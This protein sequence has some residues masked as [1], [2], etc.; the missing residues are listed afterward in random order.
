[1]YVVTDGSLTDSG[2][3]TIDVQADEVTLV[4]SNT[5]STTIRDRSKTTS[6]IQVPDAMTI[7]DVNVQLTISHTRDQDLDVYL[8]S[9]DGTRVELFT[10]VGG[11]GDHFTGTILDDQ[12]SVSITAG[13][14]PFVGTYRPE[15]S[16]A[17]LNGRNALGTW[18]L[19]ITDDQWLYSGTLHGWSITITGGPMALLADGSSAGPA[20]NAA[21]LDPADAH[22][23][24]EQAISWW[25]PQVNVEPLRNI[26][27]YVSD[28]PAGYLGLAWGRSLTLDMNANGAGWF[29]DTA[30]GQ[31]A[32][33]SDV[34]A[35]ASRQM[36][37]LTVV[38]HEVGHLLGYDHSDVADDLMYE[39]LTPGTRRLPGSVP[40]TM[41]AMPRSA[42]VSS[43][44]PERLDVSLNDLVDHALL[45]NEV[46]SNTGADG[47]L[48]MLPLVTADG[49]AQP[50]R[51]PD[52]VR[53]RIVKT[54][55][56]EE[57]ALLDEELLDLLAASQQ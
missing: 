9:P 49:A 45:P 35:T 31:G 22:W 25:A 20:T 41:T 39:T 48:W 56:D 40:V 5:T 50:Q 52:T 4:Y 2:T 37:L 57:S 7:L 6:T 24:V 46:D 43:L 19:E 26:N 53:A 23:A 32:A 36:D 12:A 38:A 28:L 8:I 3:V 44:L 47:N 10:D 14:A 42:I 27:V 33:L 34:F 30:S 15:G 13:A 11:N 51:T 17:A 21:A 55:V 18:T 54:I 29:V 1:M 16:L